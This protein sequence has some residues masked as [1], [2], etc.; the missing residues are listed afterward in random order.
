MWG[1]VGL[2]AF[3]LLFA[4]GLLVPL[5]LLE[6]YTGTVSSLNAIS[7]LESVFEGNFEKISDRD[8]VFTLSAWIGCSASGFLF[9]YLLKFGLLLP[10]RINSVARAIS[11]ASD[12][13]GFTDRY[14]SIQSRIEKNPIVRGAWR[15][16]D[17]TLVKPDANATDGVIANT[18]RPSVF[19]NAELA[20]DRYF[21][22]K[23]M[24]SLPGYFVGVGLL[25]TFIGLVLALDTAGKAVALGEGDAMQEATRQL[26]SVASFKFA[27]SIAGL[28][29]SIILGIA[30]RSF[31]IRVENAFSRICEEAERMLLYRSP[32]SISVEIAAN[33]REQRDYL[34]DITQGD[35]FQRFGQE[36][37][38]RLQSAVS[39]AMAPVVSGIETAVS[40]LANVSKSGTEDLLGKFTESLHQGAGAELKELGSSI[41][42]IQGNLTTMQAAMKSTSDDFGQNM[43]RAATELNDALGQAAASASERIGEA[44]DDVLGALGSQVAGLTAAM[45]TAKDVITEQSAAQASS[46]QSIRQ[47]A[48]DF[49]KTAGTFERAS[50]P[51]LETGNRMT[52]AIERMAKS[53]EESVEALENEKEEAANLAKSINVT[54]VKMQELW[55]G[56]SERFE[57]ID[58]E[59]GEAFRLMSDSARENAE[60][61]QDYVVKVDDG[62]AGAVGKLNGFLEQLNENSEEFGE[63]V[64]A[65]SETLTNGRST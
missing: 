16:F 28:A 37:E 30:F 27:T 42:A 19:L 2:V 45:S 21:G 13:R 18:V 61:L 51:L 11:S 15:E 48:E 4:V 36:F 44:M 12:R 10:F 7:V 41:Q 54:S 63:N 52:D 64:K 40:E 17:E 46:A 22:L 6:S 34:K 60:R 65:L 59:L 9:A 38:P 20:R 5:Q 3:W 55:S 33:I 24:P 50:S 26:L 62:L 23:M 57:A 25:L 32:Q 31:S 8:F 47:L 43:S 14:D 35:F 39:S 56:Y 58:N 53:I 49:E 29:S 1:I